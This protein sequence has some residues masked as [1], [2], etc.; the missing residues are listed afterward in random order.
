MIPSHRLGKL[1]VIESS[2][3]VD[4]LTLYR[5]YSTAAKTVIVS[6]FGMDAWRRDHPI[7]ITRARTLYIKV[8][9]QRKSQG[10][11]C[12]ISSSKS[13]L[14]HCST[15]VTK[16]IYSIR[17]STVVSTIYVSGVDTP[18]KVPVVLLAMGVTV[19]LII[20]KIPAGWQC[21]GQFNQY[22][23]PARNLTGT[24]ILCHF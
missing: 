22:R 8:V 24:I 14:R 2:D 5:P 4:P 1:K 16:I 7:I 18:T 10:E 13:C 21:W 15:K 20:S 11:S 9:E 6:G 3:G 19:T 12:Y 17:E 23:Q